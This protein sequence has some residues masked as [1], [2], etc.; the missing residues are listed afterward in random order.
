MKVL[1]RAPGWKEKLDAFLA[2][3]DSGKIRGFL[4]DET[5]GESLFKEADGAAKT[6]SLPVVGRGC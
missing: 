5:A 1:Y 4:D 2:A 6:A 3:K